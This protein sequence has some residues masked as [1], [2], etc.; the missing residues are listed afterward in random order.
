MIAKVKNFV[1]ESYE[2]SPLAFFCEMAEA[3]LLISA[4]AVLTYT[5]L[6]PA[7]RIFIPLYFVGSCLGIVSTVIRVAPMA[8]ILCTWFAV[9][10]LVA[11][12]QL[13]VL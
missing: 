1:K 12:I 2:Q 7:T 4:S 9:M 5:V 11:M 8:T 3:T 10:N 6:D 13:F